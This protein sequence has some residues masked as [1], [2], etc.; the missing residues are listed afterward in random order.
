MRWH[1]LEVS[2]GEGR[3]GAGA[4]GGAARGGRARLGRR[5]AL[6]LTLTHDGG[7]AA[8][9]GGRWRG[10]REAGGRAPRCGPST[11]PP[12]TACGIPSLVLMERAGARGGRRR[13]RR[14]PRRTAA[15]LVVC[16]GGNNGGDGYVAARLLR[17]AGRAVRVIALVPAERLQR[18][19]RGHRASAAPSGRACRSSSPGE[20]AAL[21]AGPGDVVVDALLGTGLTRPPEGRVRGGHRAPSTRPARRGRPGARGGRALRPLGRHRPAA[22]P[23]RRRPTGT[24][25]FAFPKRGLVL[26]PGARWPATVVVADIGIPPRPRRRVRGRGASCSTRPRRGALVPPRA[27]EAHKGDAGRLLV[28]AGSP[29]KTGAAQLAL[30]G[31]AARRGRPGDA[32]GARRRC[33]RS[34]SPAGRRR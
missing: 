33:C 21:G 13:R 1:D 16:G 20:P 8:A 11:G 23:L 18:R 2:R 12:S 6:H 28:V 24:I 7:V 3:A 10:A 19:R 15:C 30:H 14:W 4:A 22:R 5:R 31:R 26:Y 27:A 17:E 25:T 34:R 29:G 32:G 9:V